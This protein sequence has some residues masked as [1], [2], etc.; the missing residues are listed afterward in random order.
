MI[1]VVT[2]RSGELLT[3]SHDYIRQIEHWISSELTKINKPFSCTYQ[4]IKSSGTEIVLRISADNAIYYFKSIGK[5]WAFESPLSAYLSGRHQGKTANV[6]AIH[7]SEPWMLLEEITG[8]LLRQKRDKRVW[9]RALQ[10]YAELQVQEVK[11]AQKLIELGVPDRRIHILKEQ[12][13]EHLEEMCQTGLSEEETK[14][15]MELKPELMEMCEIME[16]LIPP[17]LDHGDLHSA[18]IYNQEEKSVFIDWGDASVTHPF[19]STRIFWNSLDEL[20]DESEWLDMTNEF[21]PYYLEPWTTFGP[22]EELDEILKVSDQ[23]GCVH[24][25]IGWHLYTL[26]YQ[27]REEFKKRPAQW[28]QVLLEHRELIR[29]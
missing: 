16:G 28:L 9:Q 4:T 2:E 17:S 29:Q 26:P 7:P 19:F 18:N 25:A 15:I 13:D 22:I 24:R 8:T 27:K 11:N 20:D 12:I 5:A 14:P 21:R 3:I 23:L 6:V 1:K 10:E